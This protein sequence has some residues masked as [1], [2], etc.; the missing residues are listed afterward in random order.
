MAFC[1]PFFA[2]SIVMA[3]A[4]R[5]ANDSRNPMFISLFSMWIIR[6]G[7]AL[8]LVFGFGFGLEGVWLAMTIE[9][10]VRGLLCALRWR[11]G[12]WRHLAGF[13]KD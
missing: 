6:M 9:L 13:T 11:S 8:I 10:T 2:L 1:E 12:K 7:L 5:G 4:L 3:G